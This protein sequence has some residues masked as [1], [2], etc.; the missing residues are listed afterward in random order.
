[1][2]LSQTMKNRIRIALSD[3][4]TAAQLLAA[5]RYQDRPMEE[6]R[7]GRVLYRLAGLRPDREHWTIGAPTVISRLRERGHS[8]AFHGRPLAPLA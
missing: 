8:V 2:R 5:M 1:M 4:T 6:I 7:A 3:H